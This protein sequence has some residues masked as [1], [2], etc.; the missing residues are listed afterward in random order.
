MRISSF[1]AAAALVSASFAAHADSFN[2]TFGN[3]SDPLSGSGVL[4]TGTLQAPG[5][6]SIASVTGTAA[7]LPFGSN[8]V[9]G[10]ILAPGTFPT[11][12]NG[13]TFPANDNVL[14][15]TNGV[16]SLD[17]NGLAFVLSNGA[18]I[19]LYDPNGSAY[20]ALLEQPNGT[21]VFADVPVTITTVAPVPEPSSFTLLGTGLMGV[22]AAVRRR[23]K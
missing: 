17:G 22:A 2:F 18:Q 6:F 8:L 5:E 10:S 14:F 11:I 20:D 21:D 3:A 12:S 23:L 4:T 19:N 1:V 16:G 15:V 7:T 9:I 13:G